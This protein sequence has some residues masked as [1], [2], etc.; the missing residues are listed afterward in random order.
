VIEF[1]E[2][3]YNW[4]MVDDRFSEKDI[5]LAGFFVRAKPVARR[6]GFTIAIIIDIILIVTGL[7]YWG[8]YFGQSRLSNM[9]SNVTF[10][11]VATQDAHAQRV[12]VQPGPLQ[13]LSVKILDGSDDT[14]DYVAIVENTND[15]WQARVSYSFVGQGQ[16]ELKSAV[17]PPGERRVLGV[18]GSDT[19]MSSARLVFDSIAWD[20]VDR[21]AVDNIS[22]FVA[23][24]LQIVTE[25][26]QY[27]NADSEVNTD[28]VTFTIL[29]ESA[30]SYFSV[31]VAAVMYFGGDIIGVEEVDISPFRSGE[32]QD[33]EIHTLSRGV[34][35]TKV[36]IL[37]HLDIFDESA[38][39]EIGS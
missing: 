19:L 14:R 11:D 12:S 17:L 31:R 34:K 27:L 32:S 16:T 13:T 10:V 38:Y 28:R 9:Q 4:S 15:R 29:N 2:A 23:E 5:Q 7:Y 20:R 33:I 26:T 35:P 39:I 18:Y 21:H 8:Q 22:D 1:F 24:R 36:E 3:N 6:V 25:N 37:P 30:Y